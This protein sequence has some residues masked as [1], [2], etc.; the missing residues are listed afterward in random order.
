MLLSFSLFQGG[1]FQDGA[2]QG[3]T[4]GSSVK[5]LIEAETE[6]FSELVKAAGLD[7]HVD[8]RFGIFDG[9]DLAGSDIREF[10]F[11]G[12]S[13]KGV[14]WDDCLKDETTILVDVLLDDP[15]PVVPDTDEAVV[16]HLRALRSF[17][18][19]DQVVW[20]YNIRQTDRDFDAKL[21][22]ALTVFYTT[23]SDF[24]A[25]NAL[26]AVCRW[27]NV[28]NA[29]NLLRELIDNSGI[30]TR[31]V[32]FAF[33]VLETLLIRDRKRAIYFAGQ[34]VQTGHVIWAALFL[35]KNVE[36][37]SKKVIRTL[38][39]IVR[40]KGNK[41]DRTAYLSSLAMRF[42][43]PFH[44]SIRSPASG[45][46]MDF[47]TAITI[48]GIYEIARRIASRMRGLKN[49]DKE[50][51][52]HYLEMYGRSGDLDDIAKQIMRNHSRMNDYGARYMNIAP[53]KINLTIN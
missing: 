2:F 17:N 24:V 1:V 16:K 44:Q 49:G 46:A 42:G 21:G 39:D 30:Y 43:E 50:N 15:E 41:F 53:E 19:N 47:R 5:S 10:D 51:L 18:E 36:L 34:F 6:V 48:D 4:F 45:D 11:T 25:R 14:K 9:V 40:T 33:E 52:S 7:P 3:D 27:M 35:V 13:M 32:R 37:G 29:L 31:E 20:L 38:S 26:E 22:A 23:E 28:E 12:A 8:L